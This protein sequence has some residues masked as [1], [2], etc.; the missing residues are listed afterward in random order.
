MSAASVPL[1]LYEAADCCLQLL[2]PT[3][4]VT[5]P[6]APA[7]GM[8][9]QVNV[10]SLPQGWQVCDLSDAIASTGQ[11]PPW[12]IEDL[13]LARSAT[14]VSGHPHSVKSFSWLDACLEAVAVHKVWGHFD[15]SSVKSSLFIESEDSRWVLE[16]RLRGIAK[17]LGLKGVEDAPGFHYLR[18][19]P[20]DLASM[21]T[22]LAQI[23]AHYKPDF[24]VLSTLQSLLAGRSWKEQQD[25]Q[26]VNSLIVRLADQY[27]PIVLITHSPW[28]TRQKRAIGTISQAANFL[29]TLHFEKMSNGDGTFVHVT[30]DSKLGAEEA[31]FTLRLE[32]AG[33]GKEREV[34]RLIYQGSGLPRGMGKAAVM[35]AINSDPKASSKEIANLTGVSPRY[36]QKIR[37]PRGRKPHK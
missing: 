20:F 6:L 21:E 8:E 14:Q 35:E 33:E 11:K 27:C 32:T 26:P 29:T 5:P 2:T 15:A 1:E 12:V 4:R 36:V 28:D 37:E 17:G 34:R 22:T 30:L 3:M 24:V 19:G 18:T 16:Q 23:L 7:G 9:A 13:L 31:D 25:M 10:L